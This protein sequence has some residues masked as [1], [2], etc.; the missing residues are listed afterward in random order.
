MNHPS[1]R[2]SVR[3][4]SGTDRA[5]GTVLFTINLWK[6]DDPPQNPPPIEINDCLRSED[7]EA[8]RPIKVDP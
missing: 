4:G 6:E 8:S 3:N 2:G 1:P 5:D 7:A